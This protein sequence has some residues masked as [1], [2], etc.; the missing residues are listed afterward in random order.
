MMYT[1]ELGALAFALAL[2]T[3]AWGAGAR[4]AHAAGLEE[5][6]PAAPGGPP[7]VEL[8]V[9]PVD[10]ESHDAH[11]VEI[12]ADASG[13][14]VEFELSREGD[15]LHLRARAEGFWGIFP[16]RRARVRARVPRQFAL[17]LET[18][19]RRIDVEELERRADAETSGGAID[20]DRVEGRV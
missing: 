8:D 19:G 11:E 16:A 15:E 5:T 9:G 13:V 17:R 18:R 1:Q 3:A 4:S 10:V 20:V 6:V 12:D 2:A 14:G 7:H